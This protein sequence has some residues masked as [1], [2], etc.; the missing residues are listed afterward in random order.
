MEYLI[1]KS[2]KIN[3][4]DPITEFDFV[5]HSMGNMPLRHYILQNGMSK[6][7]KIVFPNPPF[8]GAPDAI[9]ALTVGQGFF[10][11]RD[12]TRKMARSLPALFE[13]LPNYQFAQLM[14]FPIGKHKDLWKLDSWQFI[15]LFTQMHL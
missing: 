8:K 4:A 2:G 10:F 12:E 14:L 6:I 11:N 13:L 9:S 15:I 5:T 7:G 3:K 1:I